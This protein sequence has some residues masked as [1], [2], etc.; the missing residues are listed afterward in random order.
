HDQTLKGS[1]SSCD[2]CWIA[3]SWITYVNT[4]EKTTLSEA[5]G[6]SLRITSGVR[7]VGLRVADSYIGNHLEDDFTPLE[8]IRRSYSVIRERISFELE[9][10]TFEPERGTVFDAPPGYVRLYTHSFSLANLRLPFNELFYE[11]RP[12]IMA[13]EKEMA[14]KN[15]IYIEDYEDL[16]FLSKKPSPGFGT[17]SPSVSVNTKP[18][19]ANEE[20]DIQHVEVTVDSGGSPKPELFVVHRGS[21][22][23]RIKDKKCNLDDAPFLT[24]SDDNVGLL[25]VL[26][27]KDANAFHLKISAITP[28]AWKNHLDNHIDL[29]LLDLHDRCYSIQAVVDNVVN[30]R[31]RELL[32]VIEKLRGECDVMKSRERA[33]DEK[34]EGLRVKYEA[35]MTDF[36][37]NHVVVAL[38]EKIYTLSTEAKEHKL[39]LDRMM[40]ESCWNANVVVNSDLD[41]A[42]W[43][44]ACSHVV[45]VAALSI[46]EAPCCW[47]TNV[48]IVSDLGGAAWHRDCRHTV[49]DAALSIPAA[50]CLSQTVSRGTVFAA[51]LC[52]A[53]IFI[54][55]IQ[56]DSYH[57][58]TLAGYPSHHACSYAV[59]DA[60]LSIPVKPFLCLSG[61][62]RLCFQ[63]CRYVRMDSG[64]FLTMMLY[65]VCAFVNMQSQQ[66]VGIPIGRMSEANCFCIFCYFCIVVVEIDPYVESAQM[67]SRQDNTVFTGM[68]CYAKRVKG[69]IKL[70][71]QPRYVFWHLEIDS[72]PSGASLDCVCIHGGFYLCGAII[73]LDLG[74]PSRRRACSHDVLCEVDEARKTHRLYTHSLSLTNLRLPHP[75]FFSYDCEPS[76]D[77]FRGFFNLCRDGKWLKFAK[78]SK[79]H[80]SN[81]LPKVIT[82]IEGWHEWFFYVQDFIIPAKY[83]H[84]LSEQNKLDLKSFNDKLPPN[85]KENP[86]FQRL[87]RY[88]TS[89]RVFP[90]PILFLAGLKLSWKHGQQRPAI[91][92]GGKDDED[93]TFLPKEPS[94]GFGTGF[95]SV[96]A[97]TKPLKANEEPDIQPVEVTS[98]SGGIPKP[99]LFVVH[100]GSVA[101]RIKDRKCKTS[102][103]RQGLLLRG[104]LLLGLLDVLELKDANAC[105]LKIS[106]ITPPAWKNHLDNHID[107]ELLDLHDRCYA[108]QAI[109]DNAVN[110]R[111]RELLQVIEKLM[112]EC[113]VMRSKEGARDEE[114]EGLRVKYEAAMTN[115]EKNPAVVAIREKIY[116]LSTEAKEYKLSLDRMMLE[117]Q[118]WAGYQQSLSTL[119][120]KVTALEIEKA[121]LEA[122]EVSLRKEV[123]A[124]KEVAFCLDSVPPE[125]SGT[126]LWDSSLEITL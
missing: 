106:A 25:D 111:S 36:E 82:R 15:F 32:H 59:F 102:R 90:D 80:I 18:L 9:G 68:L 81:L 19:K 117:S 27:L 56:I 12:V 105:H 109:V 8:T 107:L 31:S 72:Y 3:K 16:T 96:S 62:T 101:A 2:G 41:E 104:T 120:S 99:E 39:S 91:M 13:G 1:K 53:R 60:A 17:G 26:E 33:R 11:Q 50:T 98:N 74:V 73:T 103:G 57:G 125:D 89:V 92:A 116:T 75:E 126:P 100:L 37:K 83:P 14:F 87:S 48:V 64:S 40:L 65:L 115:F 24:V 49:L 4:N 10:E 67:L 30:R 76:V 77:L 88:P 108:R 69:I 21:V 94:S 118:K 42:V 95:A 28:L 47:N 45:F 113:D 43:H 119:E 79:K 121:R 29:K 70:R 22:A 86:M 20:P 23:A 44:H 51:M 124:T 114:C 84:S 85:I 66:V 110:K 63:P 54:V 35:V 5:Q 34:C 58:R 123:L 122:V 71:L 61:I 52:Y 7:G 78:R 46:L 38:R 93:L 55:A 6:V 97:N 112:G